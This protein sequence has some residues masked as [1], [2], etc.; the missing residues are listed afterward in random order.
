VVKLHAGFIPRT[1]ARMIMREGL[2]KGLAEA[3]KD[4]HIGADET[5]KGS[6]EHYNF[7]E[8]M[9]SG[10]DMHD[11]TEKAGTQFAKMFPA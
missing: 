9:I 11:E 5:C 1:Y 4:G 6:D 2:E 7:F 8:S 3:K 10:R